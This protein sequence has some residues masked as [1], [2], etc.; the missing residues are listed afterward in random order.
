MT[1]PPFT[2][3]NKVDGSPQSVLVILT[4]EGALPV[5]HGR[6]ELDT[7][8]GRQWLNDFIEFH[9]RANAPGH[10]A[11]DEAAKMQSEPRR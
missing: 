1:T 9:N 6:N 3:R 5:F 7:Q 8:I 10:T 11:P 2:L 4:W